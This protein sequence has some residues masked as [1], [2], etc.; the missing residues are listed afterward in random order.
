MST[1]TTTI[2]I[3]EDGK[4]RGIYNDQFV[5]TYKQ[6]DLTIS[7]ATNIEFDNARQKWVGVDL[8]NNQ[9]IAVSTTR[10]G[11]IEQELAYLENKF[12]GTTTLNQ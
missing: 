9:E 11:A 8:S 5:D 10:Q 3:S 7:R 6:L 4:V 1:D 2:Y 12:K